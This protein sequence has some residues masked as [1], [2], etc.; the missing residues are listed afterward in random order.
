MQKI[1]GV[2][3]L[4]TKNLFRFVGKWVEKQTLVVKLGADFA[5]SSSLLT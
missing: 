2:D 1:E 4:G 5:I 3:Y